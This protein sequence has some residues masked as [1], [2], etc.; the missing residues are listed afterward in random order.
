MMT[1]EEMLKDP[2][3]NE[4]RDR[5]NGMDDPAEQ[6]EYL[7]LLIRYM[8]GLWAMF[9]KGQS[10]RN[11]RLTMHSL[12]AVLHAALMDNVTAMGMDDNIKVRLDYRGGHCH[13]TVFVNGANSGTLVVRI[14]ETDALGRA[15]LGTKII[16]GVDDDREGKA[17]AGIA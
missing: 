11:K 5:L 6:V 13:A 4:V 7:T 14:D 12:G 3:F 16:K 1:K 8:C 17:D 9:A 15:L 10:E 2:V